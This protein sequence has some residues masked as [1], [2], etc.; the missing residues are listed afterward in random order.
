MKSMIIVASIVFMSHIGCILKLACLTT[1]YGK[2]NVVLGTIC[3]MTIAAIIGA[4]IGE[5]ISKNIP[6]SFAHLISG[7]ILI[8]VGALMIFN[9]SVCSHH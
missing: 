6:H 1:Q 7:I 4:L 2:V 8:V 5:I 3:G 9:N